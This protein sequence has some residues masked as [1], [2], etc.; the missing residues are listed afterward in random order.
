MFRTW[1]WRGE[2]GPNC[3]QSG[4]GT[5]SS[6]LS[7]SETGSVTVRK[8]FPEDFGMAKGAW[9]GHLLGLGSA[10][11]KTRGQNPAG[12]RKL[13]TIQGVSGTSARWESGPPRRKSGHAC[14]VL[15]SNH[16]APKRFF[17]P[18]RNASVT[19]K[20]PPTG[21]VGASLAKQPGGL[22]LT[23][24]YRGHRNL[25]QGPP[26]LPPSQRPGGGVC[27]RRPGKGFARPHREMS[28]PV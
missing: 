11:W 14:T 6:F 26:L 22:V 8:R 24:L 21:A 18:R 15:S 20:R 2:K 28:S 17:L 12:A 10:L 1:A 9:K 23:G 25:H 5:F 7:C 13:L 27:A 4:L 16:L 19:N 3:G